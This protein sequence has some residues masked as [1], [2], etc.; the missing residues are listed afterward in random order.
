MQAIGNHLVISRPKVT[1]RRHG[2]LYL[3]NNAGDSEFFV[4]DLLSVG[5]DIEDE[6]LH[7][8]QKLFVLS[9][10]YKTKIGEKAEEEIFIVEYDGIL[11]IVE[12][13]D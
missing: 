8:G 1:E 3:P 10:A 11:A 9:H 6:K 13:D 4:A 7:P 2:S 5:S 12:D